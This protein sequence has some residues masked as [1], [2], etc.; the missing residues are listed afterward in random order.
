MSGREIRAKLDHP[1]IDSD[2][3]YMEFGPMVRERLRKHGGDEVA[4]R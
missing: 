2:A 3:H 4:D 1:V